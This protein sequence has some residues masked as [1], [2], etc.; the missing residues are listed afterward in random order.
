[1]SNKPKWAKDLEQLLLD[2]TK[3]SGSRGP[4]ERVISASSLGREPYYLMLQY[5]HGKSDDQEE[6]GANTIGS[7]YQLGL[8]K[9]IENTDKEGRY[10]TAKRMKYTLPNGWVVSGEMDILD[11]VEKVII[12]GKLLSGGGY[13]SAIEN[14]IDTNYNLQLAVYIFLLY[15]TEGIEAVGALHACNKAG[16]AVKK[17][18]YSNFELITHSVEKIEE[19]LIKKTDEVQKYIDLDTMPSEICDVFK[20]GKTNGTPNRCRTYCDYNKVCPYAKDR[21]YYNTNQSLLGLEPSKTKTV[22]SASDDI[23]F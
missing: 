7:I 13:K 20:F 6:F 3:S 10:V 5:L 17:D 19:L 21:I 4:K 14:K 22:Y 8:D 23:D 9:L 11:L 18:I 12:D 2:G 16:S 1:M 15:K